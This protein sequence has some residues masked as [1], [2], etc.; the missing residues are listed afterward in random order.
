MTKFGKIEQA[1]GISGYVLYVLCLG[2]L[3]SR[4]FY[5]KL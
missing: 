4:T 5:Y 2:E 3:Y 1:F